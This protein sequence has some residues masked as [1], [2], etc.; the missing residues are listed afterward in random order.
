LKTRGE[1][2]VE[3]NFNKPTAG[4]KKAAQTGTKV[5]EMD[6]VEEKGLRGAVKRFSVAF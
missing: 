6:V 3:P 2:V 4:G 5:G 1:L